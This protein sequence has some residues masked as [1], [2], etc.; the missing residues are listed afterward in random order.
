MEKYVLS[1]RYKNAY[2][3][4]S[5]GRADIDKI[6]KQNGFKIIYLS[7]LPFDKFHIYEMLQGLL[8]LFRLKK[9]F[10]LHVT[11]PLI[12]AP[13]IYYIL[14]FIRYRASKII[15]LVYDLDYLRYENKINLKIW[16]IAALQQA[17]E[18]IVHTKA[19]ADEL[20]NRGI[21]SPMK[22]LTLVDYLIRPNNI[23]H[24]QDIHSILFAGN[25]KRSKF[26]NNLLCEKKWN[27]NT[28]FYGIG[29]PDINKN[30]FQYMGAFHP[31]NVSNL[32][33]AW[34]LVWDGDSISTCNS[35]MLGEYLKF[36]SSHK[37]SLYLVTE[38]PI[39]IWSQSSLCDFVREKKIGIIVNSLMEIPDILSKIR[40]CD[41][42]EYVENVK[43][44]AKKLK[45]GGFLSACLNE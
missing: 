41:Y 4:G 18:I 34:G 29:C 3:A 25:L 13:F 36:N 12:S 28:Y 39:I 19:M 26:I 1:K 6:Y 20:K 17:N 22:I 38:K 27:L 40:G 30:N 23:Y 31:D 16:E 9:A 37:I 21:K 24:E 7:H 2:N 8:L 42:D 14:K 15:L 11:I 43:E 32:K 35:S 33:G 10:E 44:V 45:T 5:K